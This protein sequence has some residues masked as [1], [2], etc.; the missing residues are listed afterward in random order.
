MLLVP[1]SQEI[2]GKM[3]WQKDWVHEKLLAKEGEILP[4]VQCVVGDNTTETVVHDILKQMNGE[5]VVCKP[6]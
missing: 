2:E 5:K 1:I 3:K 6:F 4:K